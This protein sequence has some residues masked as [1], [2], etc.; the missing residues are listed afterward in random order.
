MSKISLFLIIGIFLNL[1]AAA[2][3]FEYVKQFELKKDEKAW[4]TY[5]D[6]KDGTKDIFEFSW[7]LYDN[8]NMVLH[9][10][11]RNYPRQIM[12]SL[13]R[14]LEL[15]KQIILANTRLEKQDEVALYLEFAEF[16]KGIAV[17]KAYTYDNAKRIEVEYKPDKGD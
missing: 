16:K 2:P 13:R 10:K 3:K 5:T 1:N 15:Y 9:T 17:F 6:R 11:F 14:G 4:I 8:T 12:L 7:T